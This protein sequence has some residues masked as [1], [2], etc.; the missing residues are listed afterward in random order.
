L[1]DT[2]LYRQKK[3]WGTEVKNK[4]QI[5]IAG[6]H[7]TDEEPEEYELVTEGELE[8]KDGEISFGYMESEL[9]GL[10]GV[11]TEFTISRDGLITLTRSGSVNAQ[12]VFE[13]GRKHYTMYETPYGAISMGVSALEASSEEKDGVLY[14]SI[15]Y[16]ID[17]DSSE[18]SRNIFK[19]SVRE[20]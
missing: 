14:L 16:V 12:M 20:V 1:Y 11:R 17:M 13:E 10:K 3:Q 19:I 8:R 5:T 4:V 9:T 18:I 15:Y 6:R 7:E 2:I